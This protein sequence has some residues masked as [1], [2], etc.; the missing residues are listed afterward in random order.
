MVV[1]RFPLILIFIGVVAAA[2][3]AQPPRLDTPLIDRKQ[4]SVYIVFRRMG[5]GV[6]LSDDETKERTWLSLRN[7]TR[8]PISVATFGLPDEYSETETGL[9]YTVEAPGAYAPDAPLPIGY[10]FD[11]GT[12]TEI[13]PGQELR[14]SV[15][16]NHLG[17]GLGIRVKFGFKWESNQ[18][19]TRYATVF[20]YWDLPDKFRDKVA[21]KNLKLRYGAS[22]GGAPAEPQPSPLP[23]KLEP[24]THPVPTKK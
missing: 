23:T 12:S 5:P 16:R 11:V 22:G 18:R 4:S 19:Y 20:S 15:P 17:P 7:N 2:C 8:W 24:P 6:P 13:G 3:F 10:E 14:F 1:I 9:M 21:E